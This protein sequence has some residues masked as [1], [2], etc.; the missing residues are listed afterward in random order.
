[1]LYKGE[2]AY[3]SSKMWF[4]FSSDGDLGVMEDREGSSMMRL[5]C[6]KAC[7]R[8]IDVVAI[9]WAKG[10]NLVP[11]GAKV[12]NLTSGCGIICIPGLI[13]VMIYMVDEREDGKGI[14]GHGERITLS[15]SLLEN[16]KIEIGL[17][18]AHLKYNSACLSNG[19]NIDLFQNFCHSCF[20]SFY[21]T[22][23]QSYIPTTLSLENV[24]IYL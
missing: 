22:I 15:S 10:D 11:P 3:C 6:Y 1:M 20:C 9:C 23:G 7:F 8:C 19:L 14:H 16:W 21:T 5:L 17:Y 12:C 2:G 4:P 24:F 18:L 13:N